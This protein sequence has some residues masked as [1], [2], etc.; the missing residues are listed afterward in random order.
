MWQEVRRKETDFDGDLGTDPVAGFRTSVTKRDP[1]EWGFVRHVCRLPSVYI[2]LY[3]W[4]FFLCWLSNYAVNYSDFLTSVRLFL[5]R[6]ETAVS[7]SRPCICLHAVR[8]PTL[9]FRMICILAQVRTGL[10]PDARRI[11]NLVRQ[12]VLC[13]ELLSHWNDSVIAKQ[14]SV[15]NIWRKE[16]V[17]DYRHGRGA[18]I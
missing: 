16:S 6:K 7:K 4:V 9:W 11:F 1:L 2:L 17:P 15:W 18:E 5:M 12:L 13:T 14:P 8:N 3:Q 10:L